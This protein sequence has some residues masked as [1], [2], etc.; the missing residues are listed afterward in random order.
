MLVRCGSTTLGEVEGG[1]PFPPW[2]V[3]YVWPQ[4]HWMARQV[5]HWLARCVAQ[6]VAHFV[7]WNFSI[8]CRSVIVHCFSLLFNLFLFVFFYIQDACISEISHIHFHPYSYFLY[9]KQMITASPKRELNP[10]KSCVELCSPGCPHLKMRSWSVGEIFRKTES[11]QKQYTQHRCSHSK[12]EFRRT[13]S[14][15]FQSSHSLQ[16]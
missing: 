2:A 13:H 16:Q 15:W 14:S 12:E 10:L 1:K 5:A 4:T 8:L 9:L 7:S 3:S 11:S 6:W